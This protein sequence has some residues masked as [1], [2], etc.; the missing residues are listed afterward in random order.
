[1]AY[2]TGQ[3][4]K[5]KYVTTTLIFLLNYIQIVNGMGSVNELAF[6]TKGIRLKS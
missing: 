3:A 5:G 4:G 2:L 1:M 6:S